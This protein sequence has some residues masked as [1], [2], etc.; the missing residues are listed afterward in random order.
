MLIQVLVEALQDALP[1]AHWSIG[2]QDNEEVSK[3]VQYPE[4]QTHLGET[5]QLIFIR[6]SA[7]EIELEQSTALLIVVALGLSVEV[8]VLMEALTDVIVAVEVLS[9]GTGVIVEGFQPFVTF[10]VDV[11]LSLGASEV[12]IVVSPTELV[13][14][15]DE[16]ATPLLNVVAP[17]VT[18]RSEEHTSELQSQR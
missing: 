1:S 5:E 7:H 14:V 3:G 15:L 9:S 4:G 10:P 13:N 12:I 18:V 2:M 11:A 6:E 16:V 17:T 8:V